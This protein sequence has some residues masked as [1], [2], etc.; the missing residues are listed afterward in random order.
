MHMREIEGHHHHH[1]SPEEAAAEMEAEA[2]GWG[3]RIPNIAF[4]PTKVADLIRTHPFWSVAAAV[5]AGLMFGAA[6]ARMSGGLPESIVGFRLPWK[7]RQGGGKPA[8]PPSLPP[9]P[10]PTTQAAADAAAPDPSASDDESSGYGPRYINGRNMPPQVSAKGMYYMNGFP[11]PPHHRHRHGMTPPRFR[12]RVRSVPKHFMQ[13]HPRAR[14]VVLGCL[15]RMS[16]PSSA[17]LYGALN[18]D[19][20]APA[21][22]KALNLNANAKDLLRALS[23]WH[24][25]EHAKTSGAI[26]SVLGWSFPWSTNTT[27]LLVSQLPGG[28]AAVAAHDIAV[29]AIKNGDLKPEHLH[30]AHQLVAAGKRGDRG[31]LMKIAGLKKGAGRGNPHAEKAL[32]TVKLAHHLQSGRGA[33]RHHHH[34]IAWLKNTYQSGLATIRHRA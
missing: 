28:A 11:A 17:A 33:G 19:L 18:D 4:S 21:V 20:V 10:D 3:G 12:G 23:A 9:P 31:A 1:H 14:T 13:L 7:R 22:T 15:T 29:K 16:G 27:K 25:A 5:I 8:A 32:D 30:K 24:H 26:D 6:T 34:P 2:M